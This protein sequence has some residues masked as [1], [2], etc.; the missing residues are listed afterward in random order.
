MPGALREADG[1]PGRVTAH[2]RDKETAQ[3]NDA[4]RVDISGQCRKAGG[5]SFQASVVTDHDDA[6]VP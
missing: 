5:N 2:E 3:F 1:Q 4:Y 6:I